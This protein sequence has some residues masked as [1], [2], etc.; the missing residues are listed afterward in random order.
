MAEGP[1][2]WWFISC[3]DA[4]EISRGLA[5]LMPKVE[6]NVGEM[7]AQLQYRLNTGLHVSGGLAPSDFLTA[8]SPETLEEI[9]ATGVV[10]RV[11]KMLMDEAYGCAALHGFHSDDHD[12]CFPTK[13]ALLHSELS[14]A[15][16][17]WRKNGDSGVSRKEL[18][19]GTQC[20]SGVA[21]EF[22][23]V[24]IRIFDVCRQFDIPLVWALHHKMLHNRTGEYR[25]GG[26]EA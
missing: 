21:E 1:N 20:P 2:K 11:L 18:K 6:S 23:D 17:D 25:H 5:L 9:I 13:V 7:L 14:E 15:L 19:F 8:D 3:V 26:K 12:R 22:A 24:L 4:Q 10:A 16:E